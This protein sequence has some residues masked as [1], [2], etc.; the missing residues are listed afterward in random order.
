MKKNYYGKNRNGFTLIEL[1][2]VIAIIAILA[3]MLL[4]ALASAKD[5]AHR[6][7]CL[8]NM[9][10]MAITMRMYADDNNDFLAWPNWE[11]GGTVPGWLYTRTGGS[12]PNPTAA[13]Y[14][15]APEEAW[16]SGLWYK[17]MPNSKAFLCAVDTKSP[18]Y[19]GGTG[20]LQ[21]ANKLSSYVMNG[22]VSGFPIPDNYYQ[23][24]TAKSSS[25]WSPLCY[26]MWEPD[27]NALG[28]NN[29]GAFVFNDGSN[30]PNSSEGI[31][32]LHSRKGGQALAIG[33][34]VNFIT[35]QD[36]R[37]QS[38]GTGGGPGGKSF[39]W[40]SPFTTTGH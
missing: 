1:L 15:A 25:V 11:A 19:R 40:W 16:K 23:F 30:Y 37:K 28:P 8:G 3:A 24:R 32:R 31:G 4:P 2:V 35:V 21:R 14:L 34:H 38:T 13:A 29:P 12:I 6:T 5:K 18:S 36:F 27:E 33:G 20:V 26:L 7:T 9:K 39:L 10:Q 17:Y 22:A